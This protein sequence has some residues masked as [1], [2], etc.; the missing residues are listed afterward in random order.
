MHRTANGGWRLDALWALC[1]CLF[2]AFRL[3]RECFSVVLP[4]RGKDVP[5]RTWSVMSSDALK[6]QVAS[7]YQGCNL[8]HD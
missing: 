1:F 8:Q 5:R 3:I 6:K 7:P 2:Q 4:Y